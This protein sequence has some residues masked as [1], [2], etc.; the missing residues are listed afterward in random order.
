MQLSDITVRVFMRCLF[1]K[2][3]SGVDNWEELYTEYID[4]SGLGKDG[5]LG[6]HV[7][8][9]NLNI[10]LFR[11]TAFLEL[12]NK[13]FNLIGMPQLEKINDMAEYGHR[14][15]W[16][17]EEPEMFLPQL[18]RIEQKEKRNYVEKLNLEKELDEM[19]KA[20]SPGTTSARNSFVIMLNVLGKEGYKIDKDKTDMLE[21]A[22][23]IKQ[24]GDEMA[25]LQNQIE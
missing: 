16:N 14:L 17:P 15:T 25:A 10:R 1:N 19:V 12:Q 24:H 5:Q 6:L 8:I 3:Y 7:A 2:D 9:H 20:E 23:M 22:L 13:V 4:L 18:I 21:L 11:I